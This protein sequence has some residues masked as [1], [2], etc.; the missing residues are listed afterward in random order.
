MNLPYAPRPRVLPSV[1]LPMWVRVLLGVVP[2]CASLLV[3]GRGIMWVQS[4]VKIVKVKV[5]DRCEV[6]VEV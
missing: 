4:E 1:Q 2:I 3:T 5:I 6:N